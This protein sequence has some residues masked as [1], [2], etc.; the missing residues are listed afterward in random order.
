[1]PLLFATT[2]EGK[3]IEAVRVLSSF[4]VSVEHAAVDVPEPKTLDL[5]E[6]I[7]AKAEIAFNLVGEPVVVEDTGLFLDAYPNFPGTY[8]K[9]SVQTIGLPGILK[10]LEGKPR[11]AEFRTAVA[12]ASADGVFVFW[13]SVRGTISESF[14]GD[15]HVKLPFDSV[16]IPEGS[17]KTF[18]E[19]GAEKDADSHRARAFRAL[20]EWL[21]K[22]AALE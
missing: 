7:R 15:S 13:G 14:A 5:E 12:L 18:A 6:T 3:V 22:E 21:S 8:T 19:M 17:A 16:F 4:G 11:G 1:M 9:Y 2:N 10:L 20:G